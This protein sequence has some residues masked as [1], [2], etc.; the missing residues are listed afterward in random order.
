M[1]KKLVIV[2]SPA[3]ARTIKRILG[4][5]F[6]VTASVGHIRDLPEKNLGIDI[7]KGF[8]PQYVITQPKV[9][10]TLKAVAKNADEIYLAPDPDREGEAIAW[11]LKEILDS[12]KS[13]KTFRRVV[14]HEITKSAVSKAFEEPGEV[15]GDL[16]DAQQARRVLDRLVG[17]QVSPLLWSKV[18]RGVSA[19]RVQSVALRI[20]CEREREI[21]AFK[22]EE[23][24]V[25]EGIFEPSA[26][27]GEQNRFQAKLMR[28]AGKKTSIHTAEEAERIMK[29]LAD[30][31]SFSVT[32]VE[33]KPQKKSAPPPFITSTLQQSAGNLLRMGASQTMSLAQQL[34]EGI[35][36]SG[37]SGGLITYMR[38][39]SVAVATEAQKACRE[40]VTSE[41]G[42][43]YVPEK[44]RNFKSSA[45]AQGAHEAIRPT[46]VTLTPKKAARFLDN[47]QLRLYSLIW[48][49]FVASQMAPAIMEKTTVDVEN[50]GGDESCV[51]Q[52]TAIV[53][54]FKGFTVLTPPKE[55]KDAK[56][57]KSTLAPEMVLGQLKKG[58][59]CLPIDLTKEQKFTEPPPRYSEATLIRE[60]ESN[61]IGRPS[62]Y[63]AIVRTIQAREYC[64]RDKGKLKPTE[65]GFQVNDYLVA[66]LP[67]LFEI[68][69][70][71]GM[72]KELD[73][74]E[75]GALNWR[76]M[77]RKFYENLSEWLSSAKYAGAP[78]KEKAAELLAL[79]D[80]VTEWEPPVKSGKR[81]YDD[82]KFS[83]SIRDQFAK[84][85]DLTEKQWT[86]LLRMAVKY[87]KAIP[88]FDEFVEKYDCS[89]EV[90]ALKV[91]I[92]ERQAANEQR[93]AQLDSDEHKELL[94]AFDILSKAQWEEPTKK[95][96]R[97]YDDKKFYSSLKRQVDQGRVLSEKQVNAFKRMAAKYAE[98][99]PEGKDKITSILKLDALDAPDANAK[100]DPE[101]EGLLKSLEAVTTWAE[102]VKK[103]KRIYDDKE[104]FASLNEQYSKRKTLTTRQVFALKKMVAKYAK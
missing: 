103:G 61:G 80:L 58:D 73:E 10:S 86:A 9:V 15:N 70:T 93:A 74:I 3:K 79:L 30:S 71:A 65:I 45:S 39:D 67:S 28:V 56:D 20:V 55:D 94:E 81:T 41:Y 57:A 66:T 89:A 72:E 16:V 52:A 40:F 34:Y 25:F 85:G 54:K 90:D 82:K 5:E 104:F 102:P 69:F 32:S 22:P 88:A 60:L 7:A 99:L 14:F 4:D 13:K 11:H 38:T 33:V 8:E 23:Y 27:P 47:N 44:T 1:S 46:D 59:G 101:I 2:E 98:T 91:E 21:M 62:T 19:G 49:R 18:R 37:T 78:E 100:P 77:L 24:W 83:T 42:T 87:K 26:T 68:G 63:A 84:D 35:D 31:P 92:A 53:T 75:N 48:K 43:E 29:I 6:E 50:S 95:R 36:G 96:G 97:T 17:Y 64:D 51:F 76:E 12:K